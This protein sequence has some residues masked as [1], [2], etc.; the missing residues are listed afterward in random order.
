MELSN[1]DWNTPVINYSSLLIKYNKNEEAKKILE[2]F[3]KNSPNDFQALNNLN[4]IESKCANEFNSDFIEKKLKKNLS[5][6]PE[7]QNLK[8]NYGIF[9][10]KQVKILI[11]IFKNL[12]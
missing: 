4:I 3:L 7:N 10:Y 2:K 12:K 9:L 5:Q 11:I 6:Q 8:F 1:F